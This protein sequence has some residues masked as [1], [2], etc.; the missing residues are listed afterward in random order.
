MTDSDKPPGSVGRRQ[1]TVRAWDPLTAHNTVDV[2]GT[3]MT[4]LPILNTSESAILQPG[5]VVGILTFGEGVGSWWIVGRWT[6]PGTPQATSGYSALGVRTKTAAGIG[7]HWTGTSLGWSTA[8]AVD[9]SA[10]AIVTDVIVGPSGKALAI[11]SA[12]TA[13]SVNATVSSGS[14][15]AYVGV[16][17]IRQSDGM[18]YPPNNGTALKAGGDWW[19]SGTTTVA[20]G[21]GDSSSYTHLY[22]G[23]T[24]GLYTIQLMYSAVASPASSVSWS[25]PRLIVIPL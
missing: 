9:G 17:A 6:T 25:N 13:I 16:Q 21:Q 19:A 1:G 2:G 10:E 23:L 3:L 22:E 14:V 12:G 18:I 4:D 11:I 5:D 7:P 8:T 20:V 24:S 15:A